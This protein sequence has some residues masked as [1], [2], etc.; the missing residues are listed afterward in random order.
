MTR[1]PYACLPDKVPWASGGVAIGSAL[2]WAMAKTLPSPDVLQA[3]AQALDKGV[4]AA[5]ADKKKEAPPKEGKT[6]RQHIRPARS[7]IA[8]QRGGNKGK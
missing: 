5:G 7:G 8:H 6:E 3:L 1:V 2:H 4:P